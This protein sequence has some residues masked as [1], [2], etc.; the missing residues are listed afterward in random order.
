MNFNIYIDATSLQLV[1]TATVRAPQVVQLCDLKTAESSLYWQIVAS[2]FLD[3]TGMEG[4]T[5]KHGF[6]NSLNGN[7]S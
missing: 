4:L 7:L 6:D 2:L 1:V 5:K 3:N